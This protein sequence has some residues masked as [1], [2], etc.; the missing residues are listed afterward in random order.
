MALGPGVASVLNRLGVSGLS[1]R[2]STH[3]R[4]GAYGPRLEQRS[5][6]LER[7]LGWRSA[8][9]LFHVS[10]VAN[11]RSIGAHGLDW[12][13]MGAAPGIAGSRSP[14]VEGCFLAG[15]EDVDWFVL[16]INN[17]GGPVD[18][19]GCRRDER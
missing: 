19:W 18:V 3:F 13:R 6:H 7:R 16:T 15:E 11:R 8:A 10:S 12:T 9:P 5:A 4:N 17:T 14:E 2:S 1:C